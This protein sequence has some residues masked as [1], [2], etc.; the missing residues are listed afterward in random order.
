MAKQ[1]ERRF[2]LRD[3][4]GV[5]RTANARVN[6]PGSWF[7]TENLWMP[8]PGRLAQRPGSA[9]FA[10]KVVVG[11]KVIKKDDWLDPPDDIGLP[12]V[13]DRLDP[14]DD[15]KGKYGIERPKV[16]LSPV[17]T[18]V[19]AASVGRWVNKT[20]FNNTIAG[21]TIFEARWV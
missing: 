7:T 14:R 19:P 21:A 13:I 5:D 4:I 15:A 12:G 17:I 9:E 10:S 8:E 16:D 3:F 6:S 2:N 18:T 20:T 11:E 1:L